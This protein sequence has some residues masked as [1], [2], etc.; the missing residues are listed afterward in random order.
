M[1]NRKGQQK[2]KTEGFQCKTRKTDPKNDQNRKS[3]RP[4]PEPEIQNS[5]PSC[6]PIPY[7]EYN[8][9]QKKMKQQTPILPNP[10]CSRAKGKT[11]NFPSL[12]WGEGRSRFSIYFVYDCS[13]YS[14]GVAKAKLENGSNLPIFN[15]SAGGGI[16]PSSYTFFGL[17]KLNTIG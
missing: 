6:I 13:C 14:M 2:R 8:L 4:P 9:W 3:Q 11:G 5:W 12:I 1:G 7:K 17:Y 10:R 15:C 16:L